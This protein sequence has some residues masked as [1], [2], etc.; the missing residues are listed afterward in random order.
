MTTPK[1]RIV[2]IILLCLFVFLFGCMPGLY[3]GYGVGAAGNGLGGP[4]MTAMIYSAIFSSCVLIPIGAF[5]LI[6][7]IVIKLKK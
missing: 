2:K 5:W 3:L 6:R 1:R 7:Y 4:I